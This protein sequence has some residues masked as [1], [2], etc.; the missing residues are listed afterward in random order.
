[1]SWHVIRAGAH[2][3]PNVVKGEEVIPGGPSRAWIDD[4]RDEYGE[5]SPYYVARVEAR[6]PETATDALVRREWIER[7]HD[8][9]RRGALEEAAEGTRS[10]LGVDPARLGPDRTVVCWRQGPVVREFRSWRGLDTME[11]A[12][13]ILDFIKT[14]LRATPGVKHVVVD[15]VGLG[16]G[17]L[18]RLKETCRELGR[19]ID[20][21]GVEVTNP[22]PPQA[23]GF[24]AGSRAPNA[25]RFTNARAQAFWRVRKLLE[26][27]RLAL[28][29]DADGLAEEL[30]ATRV[31]FASDG[32]TKIESKKGLKRRLGRSPDLADAL[33]VSLGP[34]LED[35]T[36]KRAR[37]TKRVRFR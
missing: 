7:A 23:K 17:V 5:D 18:D 1:M 19:Y 36:A 15:E 22:R 10:T 8:L 31:R 16:G 33:A 12:G 28:P 20:T 14:L 35:P 13:K 25:D 29:P 30:L 34:D 3:H 27:G 37:F 6:F 26:E 21:D 11:T 4:V 9:W 32:R 24:Q 2:D